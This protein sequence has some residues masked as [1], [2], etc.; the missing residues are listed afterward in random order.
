MLRM[1]LAV[2]LLATAVPSLS[3]AQTAAEPPEPVLHSAGV[4]WMFPD[5]DVCVAQAE[6]EGGRMLQLLH[7]GGLAVAVG[8]PGD[9]KLPRGR[10]GEIVTDQG[11]FLFTPHYEQPGYLVTENVLTDAQ[12]ALLRSTRTL[13]LRVDG[14]VLAEAVLEEGDGFPG[15]IDDVAACAAGRPGWWAKAPQP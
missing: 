11:S 10:R 13:Q 4:W 7:Q 3:A 9:R 6:L 5:K 1:C 15:V 8:E 14:K 2:A 12:L